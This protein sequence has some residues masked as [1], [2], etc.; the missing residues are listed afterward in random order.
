MRWLD[1]PWSVRK[2]LISSDSISYPKQQQ[3]HNRPYVAMDTQTPRTDIY[4]QFVLNKI[5]CVKQGDSKAYQGCNT[6]CESS[7]HTVVLHTM[8]KKWENDI[9]LNGGNN[10]LD[11]TLWWNFYCMHKVHKYKTGKCG[12]VNVCNCKKVAVRDSHSNIYIHK[13][14][15]SLLTILLELTLSFTG[16]NRR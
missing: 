2:L 8:N 16:G 1:D 7:L 13:H 5:V 9:W 14:T 11:L 12:H 3:K 10:T 4:I 6:D 15:P